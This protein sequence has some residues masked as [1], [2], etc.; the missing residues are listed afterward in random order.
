MRERVK[1]TGVFAWTQLHSDQKVR[2]SVDDYQRGVTVDKESPGRQRT[3]VAYGRIDNDWTWGNPALSPVQTGR[4]TEKGAYG[5]VGGDDGRSEWHH[6]AWCIG[7]EGS[8][9]PILLRP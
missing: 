3:P 7:V 1:G 4:P 6:V 9:F 2:G 5:S 8:R